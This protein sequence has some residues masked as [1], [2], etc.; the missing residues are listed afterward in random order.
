MYLLF[1]L[2]SFALISLHFELLCILNCLYYKL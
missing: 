1:L 2:L